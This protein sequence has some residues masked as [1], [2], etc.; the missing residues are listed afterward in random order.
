MNKTSLHISLPG[1]LRSYVKTQV[2]RVGY[3]TPSEYIRDLIR[4]DLKRE[5]KLGEIRREIDVGI[6]QIERGEYTEYDEASLKDLSAKI[7]AEG[8][9]QLAQR[10]KHKAS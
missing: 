7:K 9:R 4:E 1:S 2:T 10:Q 6:Q 8:R 5:R 3:S